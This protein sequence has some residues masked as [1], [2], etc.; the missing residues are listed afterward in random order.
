MAKNLSSAQV[1][2]IDEA[3]DK[4]TNKALAYFDVAEQLVGQAELDE[5]YQSG[6]KT[7]FGAL[8]EG[9]NSVTKEL[10]KTTQ[11]VEAL[12]AVFDKVSNT[13][14]TARVTETGATASSLFT[15]KGI[16]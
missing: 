11:G 7:V 5:T 8:E 16:M 9:Q 10:V 15:G 14:T 6:L 2:A 12:K 3:V 13:D 4:F 1:T